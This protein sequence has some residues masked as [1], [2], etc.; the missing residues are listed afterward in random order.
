MPDDGSVRWASKLPKGRPVDRHDL[1]IALA[2]KRRVAHVGFVDD[3]LVMVKLA[4][5]VW[6]HERLAAAASSIV[7]LDS[8]AEGVE[9]ACGQGYEAYHADA[10]NEAELRSL[11]LAPFDVIV[12]GEVIEHLD[13]PGPFLRALHALAHS[14]TLLA[15]TTPNAYRL[16]N[17]LVPLSGVELVH[18]DHT[19]WQSASTLRQL[20]ARNGWQIEKLSY[21]HT[22]IRRRGRGVSNVARALKTALTK[23]VPHWSDGLVAL[24]RPTPPSANSDRR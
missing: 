15:I 22:P 10:Q 2:E 5:G 13:A 6:L 17:I 9:W 20:H 12:A 14:E 4:G 18:P 23:A 24:S 3:R 21:Y 11:E 1:L 19:S 7:G 16:A 8:S